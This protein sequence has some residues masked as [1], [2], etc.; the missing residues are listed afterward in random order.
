MIIFGKS[1]VN[2][3]YF[4]GKSIQHSAAKTA[5]RSSPPSPSC[6]GG[7]P[8]WRG[9]ALQ[10]QIQRVR[11]G[12]W[13][14]DRQEDARE[15]AA[16]VDEEDSPS[17][18]ADDASGVWVLGG[19]KGQLAEN[20]SWGKIYGIPQSVALKGCSSV[21]ICNV[22]MHAFVKWVKCNSKYPLEKWRPV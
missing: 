14:P 12:I 15:D 13:E 16:P 11:A 22:T 4:K 7:I 1:I 8:R 18:G 3:I 6:G 21:V 5:S 2:F 20:P 17:S 19:E 10:V 9:E